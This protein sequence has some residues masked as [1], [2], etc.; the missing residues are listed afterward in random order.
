MS[1]LFF[2]RQRFDSAAR[3]SDRQAADLWGS[4]RF[5]LVG[6]LF[7]LTGRGLNRQQEPQTGKQSI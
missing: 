7:N 2:G 1:R 6:K 4:K 3:A 5:R